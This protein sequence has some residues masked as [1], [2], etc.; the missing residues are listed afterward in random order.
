M[1]M[2]YFFDHHEMNEI[3][4]GHGLS[5]HGSIYADGKIKEPYY[6]RPSGMFIVEHHVGKEGNIKW[7]K[8][9]FDTKLEAVQFYARKYEEFVYEWT[10]MFYRDFKPIVRYRRSR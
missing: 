9:R 7:K 4:N 10:L 3:M 1:P 2:Y 5:T 6:D 8:A